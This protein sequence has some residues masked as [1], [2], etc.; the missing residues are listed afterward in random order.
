MKD[1]RKRQLKLLG[2][3][4]RDGGLESDCMLGRFGGIRARGRQ[5]MKFADSLV[6]VLGER[7]AASL[8]RIAFDREQWCSMV[9]DVT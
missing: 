7:E 9:T 3:I 2:N 8:V 1:I 6:E 4:I 5:R